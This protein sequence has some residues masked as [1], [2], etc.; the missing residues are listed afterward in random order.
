M[1]QWEIN[2]APG[3]AL[4]GPDAA[5]TFKNG[6]K[7]I[8]KQDRY[9]ATFMTKPWADSSG[10]GCHTHL[11]LVQM[12]SG[13]NVF[14]E[15]ADPDGMSDTCRAFIAGMLRYA[16]A[17]DAVVAPT[18]N[19]LRRRR[20]HTFSPSNISWGLEDR[21]ALVRVKGGSS[22]S[23]HVEYRAPSAMS[24]PYLVGAALIQAGLRG[25]ED[26]LPV[27]EPSKPGTPAEEDPSFE[28]LPVDLRESLDALEQE[29]A[30]KEFFGEEFVTAY[31][32]MRR[33]ELA[34]FDDWV[35]DWERA[36]YVEMF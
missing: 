9:L 36:E 12:E 1:S 8:A 3:G 35:T 6:V 21:S 17:I 34:R 10:S 19:C 15:E 13:K 11:S 4:A 5:F 23:K 14:G 24:N 33:H 31:T 2:F 18:V 32:G 28:R 16:R 30:A 27:P 26:D 29:P 22:A 20:P 7:E 25:I